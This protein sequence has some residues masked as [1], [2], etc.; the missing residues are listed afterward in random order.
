MGIH[1]GHRKNL[2][3][4]FLKSG[5][6]GKTE[7]Q[8]LELLL[9]YSIPRIDVNPIAHELINKFGSLARVIDAPAKDLL[10]IPYI[11]EN[12]V[13]LIKLIPEISK[14]YSKSR[15]GEKPQLLNMK[16]VCNYLRPHFDS[17]NNEV[18]FMMC[19][20]THFHLLELVRLSE[21]TPNSST[22]YART[23][24]AHALR[25]SATQ[26]IIA[27]NHP[28]GYS[29]YSVDD[30]IFT[31]EVCHA[32]NLISV[33]LVDHLVFAGDKVS[34]C[35]YREENITAETLDEKIS[36]TTNTPD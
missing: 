9:T 6:D 8:I 30:M 32:L 5:L 33:K 29:R 28:S 10:K 11:T 21:G 23:I 34:S 18:I 14:Q 25:T 26:I 1:D 15:W 20:D 4:S 13:V 19:F 16:S 24:V 31:N 27:H 35:M 3:Q 17:L 7:H 36:E 2:R 12:S 22:T